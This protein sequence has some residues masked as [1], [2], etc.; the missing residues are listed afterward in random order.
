[1]YGELPYISLKLFLEK[2]FL[3]NVTQSYEIKYKKEELFCRWFTAELGL[4]DIKE[5]C[6]FLQINAVKEV[7]SKE[8][9]PISDEQLAEWGLSRK[10]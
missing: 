10:E 9:L 5:R 4:A 1:M 8:T 3:L 6:T 7:D 2:E